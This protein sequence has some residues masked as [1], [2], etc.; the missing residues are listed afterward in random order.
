MRAER[1]TG[2]NAECTASSSSERP[3]EIRILEL[4]CRDEL[5]LFD[6]DQ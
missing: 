6:Y 4:V 5:A 2:N 3:E 1:D